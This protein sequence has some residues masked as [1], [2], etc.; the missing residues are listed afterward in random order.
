M[1]TRVSLLSDYKRIVIKIGSA[2][3]VED[4]RL[5][6]DWLDALCADIARLRE[7]GATVTLVS[8]GAIALGCQTLGLD[9]SSLSLAQKQACAAVGQSLL[10]RG[11]DDSLQG[12]GIRAAQAL[13]TLDDTEVRR[14]YLNA[15]ATLTTLLDL[16]VVPIV[17]ENDTVATAEIR[18]GDNDR[19]AART[20]QMLGADLLILLSDV[21]G[22][23]TADPRANSDAKH[24]P[25]IE[26]ITDDHMAM[27][28]GVNEEAG[29]GSGG[30][31]TKLIAARIATA[32]GCDM[33]VCD[34]RSA[35]AI[36]ALDHGAKHTLFKAESEP[37]KARAQWIAGS[38]SPVGDIIID[39]GAVSAL[40]SGKS[41]LAAGLSGLSGTFGKGDT[42][43][44]L[45]QSGDA[46]AIGLTA[47]DS[48]DLDA[49]MGL[50]SEQ[51]AHP[52]GPVVVHRDNLVMT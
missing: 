52:A 45:T 16:G 38:L 21:D 25:V 42:V 32:A 39:D 24:L 34:G 4:G 28:S 47:Y 14:R 13:L 36:A 15:R 37:R 3:L 8:S 46:M 29:V 40:R 1:V 23:Y 27:A 11:Y 17:N 2:I 31:A 19:L 49:V 12:Y 44:I 26:A 6:E 33:I 22:L 18:Y 9:R 43:R 51:I 20:A 5:R 48:R 50:R 41:L 35:G 7:S 10:T 30:M